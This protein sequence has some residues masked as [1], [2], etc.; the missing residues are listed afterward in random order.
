MI[1]YGIFKFPS[2]IGVSSFTKLL[3]AF[4][5]YAGFGGDVVIVN[6]ADEPEPEV[7]PN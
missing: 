1:G 6:K 7:P 4:S 3:D 5:F 2:G